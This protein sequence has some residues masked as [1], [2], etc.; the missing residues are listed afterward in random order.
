MGADR[1]KLLAIDDETD[2]IGM[3][4]QYFEPRGYEIDIAPDGAKGFELFRRKKYDCVL[5]DLKMS[6]MDGSEIMRDM[7]EYDRDVKIIFITAFN[8][9]GRT[10]A[11]LMERGAF[12]FL[13]KPL[14]GLKELEG[15]IAKAVRARD[16]R[17]GDGM[18][19]IL[20]VDD[21]AE[22]CDFVKNFFKDR[23]FE[24]FT[25]YN[26]EEALDI[27]D[28]KDPDIILLDMKMPGMDGIAVLKELRRRE[29]DVKVIMVTAISDTDKVEEAKKCGVV[30]YITK[31]LSLERLE[32][33]VVQLAKSIRGSEK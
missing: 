23:Q 15:V 32:T 27:V 21:E 33:T 17:K 25:A 9:G 6:G 8:D 3:L 7:K 20:V 28:I 19:K 24:V 1:I 10:R 30:D 11:Q 4:K 13:E 22:I 14:A 12:A 2:F 5:L 29:N 18:L 31:P 16:D 26:G